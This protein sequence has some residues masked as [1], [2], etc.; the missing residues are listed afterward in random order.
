MLPN[1]HDKELL[2][3]DKLSYRFGK[4]QR[5]DVII[6]KA[7]QGEPCADIEC[8]YI[9][10]V[11]G[12]PGERIKVENGFVYINGKKLEEKYLPSDFLTANGSYLREGLEQ[13]IPE[14]EY[15]PLGD[16]RNHSRDGREFGVIPFESIVGKA[17]LRYW[18]INTLGAMKKVPYSL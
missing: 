4:P 12:L 17:I 14:R 1:F 9:K 16:N 11:I 6:F 18:P 13:K 5:G 10:R 3:T 8:E 2:L 15:L 7:P